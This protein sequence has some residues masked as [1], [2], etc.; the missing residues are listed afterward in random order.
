[1]PFGTPERHHHIG[2]MANVGSALDRVPEQVNRDEHIVTVAEHRLKVFLEGHHHF[3][4]DGV[5][6]N[7][8]TVCLWVFQIRRW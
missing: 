1:M 5:V 3:R 6:C 8:L 2:R 4:L 7:R